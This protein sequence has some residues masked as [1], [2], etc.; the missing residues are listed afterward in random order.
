M[1]TV[2]H[3]A[4]MPSAPSLLHPPR[5]RLVPAGRPLFT[6]EQFLDWLLPGFWI[7]RGW[8]EPDRRPTGRAGRAAIARRRRRRG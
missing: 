6:S 1:G 7:I 4:A 2:T 3:S 5:P 8:L